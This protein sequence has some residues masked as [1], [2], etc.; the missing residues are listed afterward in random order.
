MQRNRQT[1]RRLWLFAGGVIVIVMALV[2]S[3]ISRDGEN[4]GGS[5]G[6]KLEPP[7][8]FKLPAVDED[9]ALTEMRE[10]GYIV[11]DETDAQ[12]ETPTAD[13][14]HD[15]VSAR[16]LQNLGASLAGAGDLVA[17]EEAFRGAIAADPTYRPPHY[18][19]SKLLRLTDRFDEADRE[20][21]ISVDIGVGEPESSIV[22]VATE[23]RSRGEFERAGKILDE[24]GDIWLHFGAFFGEIGDYEKAARCLQRAISL[25]PD[26]PLA[27]RNLAAAQVAL[28]DREGARRTL[29]DGLRRDPKNKEIERMLAELGGSER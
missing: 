28:G 17:A 16:R 6:V 27:Y 21:W 19:L 13:S 20:F 8:Q 4:L 7:P 12:A 14:G 25:A 22:K 3:V 26:D 29:T 2:W 24:S 1:N 10:L 9:P 11:V 15:R 5:I 23:Y 18:A